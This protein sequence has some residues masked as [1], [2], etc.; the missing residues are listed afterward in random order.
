MRHE[1]E[2]KQFISLFI[3]QVIIYRS[4]DNDINSKI[5]SITK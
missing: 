2:N 1:C 4:L 5:K 3:N